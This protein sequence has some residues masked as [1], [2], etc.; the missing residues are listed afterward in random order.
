MIM[1]KR[2]IRKG[3]VKRNRRKDKRTR[4]GGKRP[5]QNVSV[6]SLSALCVLYSSV[7]T[8]S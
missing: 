3:R 8:T 7:F 2:R 6:T 5:Q 4:S 1:R